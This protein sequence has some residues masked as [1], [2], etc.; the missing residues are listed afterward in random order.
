MGNRRSGSIAVRVGVVLLAVL[1]HGLPAAAELVNVDI[2]GDPPNDTTHSG[3]DGVLSGGGTFWNGVAAGVNTAGL[4]D[5]LGSPTSM[6]LVFVSGG[7]ITDGSSTNDLQDSGAYGTIEVRGL[8]QSAQYDVAVY[9]FPF[10]FL[11]FTD[12]GG[13]SGGPCTGSPTYLL[14]GTVN[15]DYCLFEDRTP[16]D[17]GGGEYG[18]SIGGDGAVMGIQVLGPGGSSGSPVPALGVGGFAAL[19]LC[20]LGAGVFSKLRS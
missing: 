20:L 1:G 10:S 16:A 14:P 15:V 17:L 5:E 4:L 3:S 12:S 11:G 19:A 18:F 2:E 8:S 9:A 7:G 13:I 6:E